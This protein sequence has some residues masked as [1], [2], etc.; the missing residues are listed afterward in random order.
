MTIYD[1]LKDNDKDA[2]VSILFPH[3]GKAVNYFIQFAKYQN[4]I[5]WNN[6]ALQKIVKDAIPSRIKDELWYSQKN[7]SFFEGFKKAVLRINNDYW[8]SL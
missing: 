6:W 5:C 2:I 7:V 3:D 1:T 8:R 4:C